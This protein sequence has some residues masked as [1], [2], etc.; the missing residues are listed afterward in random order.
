ML[1]NFKQFY[2]LVYIWQLERETG[3]VTAMMQ[4]LM[5]QLLTSQFGITLDYLTSI[6]HSENACAVLPRIPEGQPIIFPGQCNPNI[7][8][9]VNFNV[10]A[11]SN[12]SI[13]T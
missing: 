3:I 12:N 10:V 9:V 8:V 13:F 2:L 5:N 1:F 6:D 11:V 7:N 4:A